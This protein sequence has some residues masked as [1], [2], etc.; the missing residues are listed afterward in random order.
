MTAASAARKKTKRTAAARDALLR[1]DTE[2]AVLAQQAQYAAGEAI[3]HAN[4]AAQF[5]LILVDPGPDGKPKARAV[6]MYGREYIRASTAACRDAADRTLKIRHSA[7]L[8]AGR[9]EVNGVVALPEFKDGCCAPILQNVNESLDT[10]NS[11]VKFAYLARACSLRADAAAVELS[12]DPNDPGAPSAARRG[13][14]AVAVKAAL[15][16]LPPLLKGGADVPPRNDKDSPIQL[17]DKEEQ[18]IAAA[19]E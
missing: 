1:D 17:S 5:A 19:E 18:D 15:D 4:A 2:L 8:A 13:E 11:Q 14:L 12:R 16:R 6:R 10:T 7:I 3:H 9:C